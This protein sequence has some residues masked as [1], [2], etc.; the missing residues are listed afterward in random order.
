MSF[1][2]T[3]CDHW[4][5]AKVAAAFA[6]G[7]EAEA[8]YRA[9]RAAAAV[10]TTTAQRIADEIAEQAAEEEWWRQRCDFE[11]MGSDE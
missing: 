4:W 11:D 9:E 1:H 6:A 2:E 8:E 10:T 5:R 3:I 7:R